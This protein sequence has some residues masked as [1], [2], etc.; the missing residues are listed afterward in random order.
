MG[1]EDRTYKSADV[2]A[3]AADDQ[4]NPLDANTLKHWTRTRGRLQLENPNQTG[5]TRYTWGD[6]LRVRAWVEVMEAGLSPSETFAAHVSAE[7]G[8]RVHDARSGSPGELLAKVLGDELIKVA[9][10]KVE[11]QAGWFV[12]ARHVGSQMR[13]MALTRRGHEIYFKSRPERGASKF[14]TF[15][16]FELWD[17][18]YDNL[19]R[20]LAE[21]AK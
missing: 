12:F 13:V 16:V 1:Y 3:A 4:G 11:R 20:H 17:R 6:L 9:A 2:C 19:V 18:T 15:D 8:A 14:H 10:G 7:E 5:W 21:G